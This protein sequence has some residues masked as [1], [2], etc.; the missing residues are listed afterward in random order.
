MAEEEKRGQSMILEL[1]EEGKRF[2]EDL[3]K[4]N[5]NLRMVIAKLKT[6]K[7][8]LESQYIRVDVPRMK[9]KIDLLE[10]EVRQLKEENQELRDQFTYVEEENREFAERYMEVENQN[11]DLINL[12]VASHQLHSTLNYEE[13]LTTV[14][15]VIINMIG[16]EQLG[17]YL[18]DKKEDCLQMVSHVGIDATVPERIELE[19]GRIGEAARTGKVYVE[20]LAD[21]KK[22]SDYD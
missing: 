21:G 8:D 13:V 22:K 15:D 19:E 5:E 4:E 17:I 10:D 14:K 7:R 2:T 1:F 9:Q 11:S 6:D 3:L 18:L 12:Y 16:T 20:E